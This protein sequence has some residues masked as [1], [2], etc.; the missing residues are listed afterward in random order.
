MPDIGFAT[1]CPTRPHV[2]T[3]ADPAAPDTFVV[4]VADITAGPADCCLHDRHRG[5]DGAAA[6][7]LVWRMDSVM[8]A[9]L[10]ATLTR[11]V[12][13]VAADMAKG[14]ANPRVA[15]GAGE[16]TALQVVDGA[17]NVISSSGTS[18]V[19][20]G[21]LHPARGSRNPTHSTQSSVAVWKAVPGRRRGGA[22][23]KGPVTIY[24]GSPTTTL[25]KSTDELGTA[26]TMGVP[27][28]SCS[29]HWSAGGWSAGHC[30]RST[31]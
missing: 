25:T 31:R 2:T 21:L 28:W 23:P 24:V 20:H 3:E 12:R 7:L 14:D 5:W 4:A 29:L 15:R 18:T 1:T 26:L 19:E 6:T 22:S 16:S 30:V 10:D 13:D 8:A 11:Q 9:N 27:R 17:G